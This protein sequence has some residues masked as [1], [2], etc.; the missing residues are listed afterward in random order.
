[1]KPEDAPVAGKQNEP[2]MPVAWT[3][4]YSSSSGKTGRVFTTTMGSAQDIA[5]EGLRRLLVN[6]SFWALG[7]ERQIPQRS[8]V[9]MVGPYHPLPFGFGG[10]KK[11]LKPSEL[12]LQ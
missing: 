11:G 5:N 2:M 12:E 7:M 10:F 1:M 3:K 6:A 9:D 4:T 8:N